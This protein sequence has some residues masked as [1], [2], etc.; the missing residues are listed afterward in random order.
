MSEQL[1]SFSSRFPQLLSQVVLFERWLNHA[2]LDLSVE[3]D[4]RKMVNDLLVSA[5]DM[6]DKTVVF[7]DP[8][9]E[10]TDVNER[11]VSN[12]IEVAESVE[13]DDLV[14]DGLLNEVPESERSEEKY[15]QVDDWKKG[16]VDTSVT[17]FE[18]LENDTV[19]GTDFLVGE[20]YID[21]EKHVEDEDELE[22]KDTIQEILD[23]QSYQEVNEMSHTE[24]DD[25]VVGEHDEEH[26][27]QE[28]AYENLLQ[29][30][31]SSSEL[32]NDMFDVNPGLDGESVANHNYSEDS[33]FSNSE[34]VL[35]DGSDNDMPF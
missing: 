10:A 35:D 9:A 29:N 33:D 30:D 17:D 25:L 19:E 21:P 16:M 24:D 7:V 14:F 34:S 15:R 12:K 20:V 23:N 4:L 1:N 3:K 11:M 6:D 31:V 28:T 22:D 13:L 2:N 18:E 32:V 8:K 27:R 26:L 5:L